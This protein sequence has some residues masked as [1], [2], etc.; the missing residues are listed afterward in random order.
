MK[1]ISSRCK[2]R[3]GSAEFAHATCSGRPHPPLLTSTARR[4][5]QVSYALEIIRGEELHER[6]MLTTRVGPLVDL[7]LAHHAAHLPV[8]ARKRHQALP[9]V[10]GGEAVP[11]L[12]LLD[13][14]AS[15]QRYGLGRDEQQ[16][17]TD[18]VT[19]G[20]ESIVAKCWCVQ[21][22]GAL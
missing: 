12:C 14:L 9:V 3:V 4:D 6:T 15:G 16:R 11:R 2:A 5:M 1:N 20:V 17:G 22:F 13:D 8:E 18:E 21:P 10:P 19:H 7:G